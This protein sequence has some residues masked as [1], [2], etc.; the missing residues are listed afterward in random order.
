MIALSKQMHCLDQTLCMTNR[1][2]IEQDEIVKN[3]NLKNLKLEDLTEYDLE[4]MTDLLNNLYDVKACSR[5]A[6]RI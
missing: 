4:K 2:L 5:R 6:K 3:S 1:L